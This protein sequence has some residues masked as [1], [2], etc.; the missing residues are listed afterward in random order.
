MLL[1]TKNSMRLMLIQTTHS[2]LLTINSQ[3]GVSG[4][5]REF[6]DGKILEERETKLNM[7]RLTLLL[8]STGERKELLPPSK[9]K[10]IVVHAGLSLPLVLLK[11]LTSW[12]EMENSCHSLSSN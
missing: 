4:N 9:I 1:K 11:V 2:L 12:Q 5:T 6:L 8:L 3:H 7:M 10:E